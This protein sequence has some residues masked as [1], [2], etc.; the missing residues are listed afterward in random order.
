MKPK[1]LPI[2]ILLV[3]L[4]IQLY[5]CETNTE[6][7]LDLSA[8]LEPK[9]YKVLSMSARKASLSLDFPATM[10]GQE[11]IEIRPKIDGYLDAI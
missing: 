6:K 9:N 3:L 1:H 11:I 5:S 7:K 10:Q 2:R 4:C 8:N